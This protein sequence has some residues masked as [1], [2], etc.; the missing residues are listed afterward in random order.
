MDE[1]AG[2][3]ARERIMIGGASDVRE[4]AVIVALPPQVCVVRFTCRVCSRGNRRPDSGQRATRAPL[5]SGVA[6]RSYPH[7]PLPQAT[8]PDAHQ[9]RHGREEGE[10]QH[11]A[12]A[13]ADESQDHAENRT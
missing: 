12:E 4:S 9:Q 1:A 10:V 5:G 2:E 13:G 11:A 6:R 8:Q 3:A 7:R